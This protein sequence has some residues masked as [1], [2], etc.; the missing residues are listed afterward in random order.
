MLPFIDYTVAHE[1]LHLKHA[2][3]SEDRC[4]YFTKR[5][6]VNLWKKAGYN[7]FSLEDF[8][9]DFVN[10][11][12]IESTIALISE[13]GERFRDFYVNFELLGNSS[14][15]SSTKEWEEHE[16][17][18]TTREK[19]S[20]YICKSD[21]CSSYML[22]LLALDIGIKLVL[23]SKRLPMKRHKKRPKFAPCFKEGEKTVK[24]VKNLFQRIRYTSNPNTL[25]R[26]IMA[27]DKIVG[28]STIYCVLKLR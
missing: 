11:C 24:N 20:R 9:E 4:P 22:K 26:H 14:F 1:I 15:S 5:E 6:D 18:I 8:F 10:K 27:L 23:L 2:L 19:M 25:A 7:A 28:L 16:F 3:F 17:F 12:G 21:L 13:Y